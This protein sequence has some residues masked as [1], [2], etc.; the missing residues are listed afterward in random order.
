MK[1]GKCD[2][3]G[4]G[5]A[6]VTVE[7][8]WWSVSGSQPCP[9]ILC[10]VLLLLYSILSFPVHSYTIAFRGLSCSVLTHSLT[11]SLTHRRLTDP[12]PPPPLTAIRPPPLKTRPC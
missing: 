6:D 9:V 1:T 2:G 3:G 7:V 8:R 10:P 11:D 5:G 12:P 4:G